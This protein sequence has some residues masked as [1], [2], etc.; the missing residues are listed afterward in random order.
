MDQ[1]LDQVPDQVQVKAHSRD[2]QL[3]T[4]ARSSSCATGALASPGGHKRRPVT[5]ARGRRAPRWK[6]HV[7]LRLLGWRQGESGG[8][9]P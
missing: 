6:Q 9:Q 2:V 8:D 4:D 7:D 5:Q 3:N 1:V